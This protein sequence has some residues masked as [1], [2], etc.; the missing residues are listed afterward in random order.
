MYEIVDEDEDDPLVGP[1]NE[2]PLDVDAVVDVDDVEPTLDD[3][4][5]GT[6]TVIDVTFIVTFIHR[7]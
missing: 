7:A 4:D 3:E 2:I 6:V 1:V 5:G